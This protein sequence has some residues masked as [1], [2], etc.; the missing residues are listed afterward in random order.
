MSKSKQHN[1]VTQAL[2]R[3]SQSLPLKTLDNR[4]RFIDDLP[5]R[6]LI[7]KGL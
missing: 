3:R 4:S 2:R 5:N 7:P 1:R 6:F